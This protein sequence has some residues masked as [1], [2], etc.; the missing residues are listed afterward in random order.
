MQV[1]AKAWAPRN[2]HGQSRLEITR[3]IRLRHFLQNRPQASPGWNLIGHLESPFLV[4]QVIP[5]E[6]HRRRHELCGQ[7]MVAQGQQG[8]PQDQRIDGQSGQGHGHESRQGLLMA[9]LAAEREIPVGQVIENRTHHET[10]GGSEGPRHPCESHQNKQEEVLQ[11]GGK[12]AN[13]S[14]QVNRVK[15]VQCWHRNKPCSPWESVNAVGSRRASQ[16]S[17]PDKRQ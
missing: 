9:S 14:K 3:P 10:D 11:A 1:N 5:G 13:E 2:R 15:A 4:H 6:H 17:N 16:A 12:T 8:A 7:N